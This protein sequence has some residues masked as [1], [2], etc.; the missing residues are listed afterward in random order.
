MRKDLLGLDHAVIAVH[1]LE[2]A[3]AAYNKLGFTNV[4]M[5]DHRNRATANYCIMFPDTYLELLGMNAPDLPDFGFKDFL[6]TR[7]EGFQRLANGSSDADATAADL[8]GAGLPVEGP[9]LLERPQDQPAGM[10]TFHNVM[11]PKEETAG[12][13]TFFCCH[14]TPELMRTPAWLQHR[15]G[16]TALASVTAIVEDLQPARAALAKVYGADTLHDAPYGFSAHL[17]KGR[18]HVTTPDSFPVLH[19][20]APVPKGPLPRWYAMR[21]AVKDL[22]A[23]EQYLAGHHIVAEHLFDGSLRIHPD[24]A[25]GV[26]LE[27]VAHA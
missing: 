19:I 15:N 10:V 2:K 25:C 23:T 17:P 11:I 14:R 16:A 13:W 5:G 7:G 20:G 6:A 26:M 21:I 3:R 8:N 27:F 22:G 24:D 1:D 9:V 12:I 18:V 4:P